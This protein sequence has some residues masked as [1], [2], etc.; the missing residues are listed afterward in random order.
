MCLEGAYFFLAQS[1]AML[2]PS[3]FSTAVGARSHGSCH[4][5]HD[6]KPVVSRPEQGWSEESR[7]V[8]QGPG[9][10]KGA[11]TRAEQA[12]TS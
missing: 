12:L 8:T 9:N 10:G 4:K 5:V 3:A 2:G 7:V 11:W 6:P 1:K